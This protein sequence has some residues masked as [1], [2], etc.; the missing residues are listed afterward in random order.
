MGVVVAAGPEVVEEGLGA[1]GVR[2]YGQGLAVGGNLDIH[3]D[4]GSVAAGHIGQLH[5]HSAPRRPASWPH[6]VGVI[7][8][9]A[10]CF[11]ERA[12]AARLREALT[13]G[14]TAV[15]G[16]A[17]KM[18]SEGAPSGGVLAGM[19][20]VG[21][22]QLAADYARHTWQN[23][24]VD[25]LVWITAGSA[26]AV[27]SGYAQAGIE[28]LGA[29]PADPQQAARAFL[30]WLE[31][32]AGAGPCR[33]LIVLDDVADPG[34]LRGLWPPASPH[35]RTLVTT[36][37]RDA[38]LTAGGRR[39]IDV[40]VFTPDEAVAYLS[41]V[42]AAYGRHEPAGR[43]AALAD[44]LG[45]LPLALSQAAAY[46]ADT[47]ESIA[48]YQA[49]LAD[50]TRA[51][52]DAAPDALPD[53]QG[54]TVA[55][56][57]ALSI[58]RA[59]ALR[60]TGLARP[61]LQLAAML[62]P[63]GIPQDVLTSEPALAHLAQHRAADHHEAPGPQRV[64]GDQ[65][66]LALRALHR[67]SLVDHTPGTAHR[68]VRVHQL[69]QH[70]TRD[71]LTPEQHSRIARTAADAL[72]AAW[73][74][75]ERNT[76]LTA[77]LRA[78]AT[79]L[80]GHA[81]QALYQPDAHAVLYHTGNS[82]GQAG[83]VAAARDHYQH[84]A[85]TSSRLLGPDHPDTLTARNNLA[86]W[87]GEAGDTAGATTDLVRLLADR[88]RVLGPDHPDTLTTRHNL[89]YWRVEAGD[90]TGATTDLAR[91]LADRMRV[92]TPDHP[93]T[94]TTR[95]HLAICRGQ[96]GDT[97][98]ATTDLAGLLPDMV[99]V[100][101]PD[102]PDTLTT[103]HNLAYWRAQAGDA[104]GA[105]TAFA[106][107]LPDMV[108]VLGP[109]HPDTLTTRHNLALWRGHAG[110]T[111]GAVTDLI[112]LLT[113]MV[114]VLG[115]DHP[116]TLT[117]RS[118]VAICR[119]EAGDTA[120]ATADLAELLPDMV[121]V[122]GPDHRYALITRNHLALW[123][124]Q[125]GDGAGAT[126]AF[127]ELLTDMVRVLGPDHPYTL[128]T[129]NHL[130]YWRAQAGDAAG[131]I[132]DLVQLLA[133]RMRVQGPDHPD[134]LTT[135]NH[136]AICRGQTGDTAGAATEL[137]QL[138]TDM[139]RVLG[140][141]RAGSFTTR[142]HA[143]IS[144]GQAGDAAGA[145][146]DLAELLTD[147]VRALGPD[148]PHTLTTRNHLALWRRQAGDTAGAVTDLAQLL[149]DRMRV[150]GPDHPHTLTTRHNLAIW[151]GRFPD[152]E[153]RSATPAAHA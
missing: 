110:D 85:A 18:P 26:A 129:R 76:V 97:A 21:K 120:G 31:P 104:A 5:H 79:A 130:A 9:R 62:D 147:M 59:D 143:A 10:D 66:V 68:A 93:D 118:H 72:M 74:E 132:A 92:L 39:R 119:V 84:L 137:A 109:D 88:M 41:G 139:V 122:L 96:A 24:V 49:L 23:G 153:G 1:G 124:G 63:N 7:P 29:D 94:L 38:A 35:G 115:P 32:K 123:R 141:D 148:H 69:I 65:A 47:G 127:T 22:T 82:L 67:L 142:N 151:R 111:T 56:A 44:S 78:S 90:T 75:I 144:R 40:G 58:D 146:T 33:W 113:D 98:R 91:L 117:T 108:R 150:L 14:G 89:A 80:T 4:H 53:D 37:R 136:L 133:D 46:L 17:H 105:T 11:Q 86:Y 3:A 149:S 126:T 36:R 30:A 6:Q 125:A 64:T 20:G 15:V 128:I 43:L 45:H 28:V 106:E 138:L 103:R 121:R 87:R 34:D 42:L 107:L 131:A 134:T 50:R 71:T 101:G 100:L 25:V 112:E 54:F 102:H 135:R 13:A 140:S 81:E 16:P 19:G 95:N 48:A 73:P 77:A 2:A 57:W 27:S 61:M 114:R 51:L 145:V 83:Q 116:D 70:A 52:A 152:T 8:S 55:A 60:P 99:R 12:E